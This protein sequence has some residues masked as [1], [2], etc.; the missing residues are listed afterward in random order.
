LACLKFDAYCTEKGIMV[1]KPIVDCLYDRIVDIEGKLERVQIKYAGSGYG[2]KRNV[3]GVVV[4]R[5]DRIGHNP[6]DRK[7]YT[8]DEIDAIVVYIPKKDKFCW[9]DIKEVENKVALS[10]RYEPSKNNQKKGCLMMK[11][12][13]W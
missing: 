8:S 3:L 5:L 1:S 6:K 10:I 11:K 9:F 12:Y 2:K 4:A 13:E 7:T